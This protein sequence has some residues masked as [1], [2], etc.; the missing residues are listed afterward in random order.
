MHTNTHRGEITQAALLGDEGIG[1]A[2]RLWGCPLMLG[3]MRCASKLDE[4]AFRLII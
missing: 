4:K 1:A 3:H 2:R